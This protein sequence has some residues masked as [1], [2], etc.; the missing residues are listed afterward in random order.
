MLEGQFQQTACSE[1]EMKRS[2]HFS[3]ADSHADSHDAQT[4]QWAFILHLSQLTGIVLPLAGLLA[5]IVI[6]QMKKYELPELDLHGKMV[7][8][9]IISQVIYVAVCFGLFVMAF[10]FSGIG[11]PITLMA[12]PLIFIIGLLGLIFAVIGG[13]HAKNG[14]VWHYPL[15]L[16]ILQ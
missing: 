1:D 9:W 12:F 15:S 2:T 8:N 6:W 13:M 7:L 5:P 3:T 14:N 4:N 16:P 11:N 10:T